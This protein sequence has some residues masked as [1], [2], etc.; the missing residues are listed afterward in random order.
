MK[1]GSFLRIDLSHPSIRS[2]ARKIFAATTSVV[3]WN[4]IPTSEAIE[5]F[6]RTSLVRDSQVPSGTA[7]T[8]RMEPSFHWRPSC[9]N[10]R[11]ESI[12]KKT[13]LVLILALLMQIEFVLGS[14][15]TGNANE[16]FVTFVV[17]SKGRRTLCRALDSVLRQ[18]Q[19][20]WEVVVLLNFLQWST[21]DPLEYLSLPDRITEDKRF[22]FRQVK[23]GEFRSN[24]AGS[25]RNL[26][27]RMAR[28]P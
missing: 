5:L 12:L 18:T 26:G 21:E 10:T 9:F 25:V 27:V 1:V 28:S 8:S 17:P 13:S 19:P 6:V 7:G 3:R 22:I 4:R 20:W 11:T 23:R 15:T 16:V 2:I 14:N 24:C